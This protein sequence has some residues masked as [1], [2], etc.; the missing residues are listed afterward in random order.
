[1][2]NHDLIG[3]GILFQ[4]PESA[5]LADETEVGETALARPLG[6]EI[7]EHAAGR[8]STRGVTNSMVRSA[9][10]NG[11][12]YYDP[13]NGTINYVVRRGFISGRDLLIGRNPITG[14]ITTVIRGRNLVR[15]RMIRI[16]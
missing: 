4:F 14:R 12:Q 2:L 9:I 16:R 15:P 7:S 1:M 13:A 10:R 3:S 8:M 11:E 6:Q 5:G